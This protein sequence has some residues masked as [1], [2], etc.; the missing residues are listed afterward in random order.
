MQ[1]RDKWRGRLTLLQESLKEIR[2][3][4]VRLQKRL[5]RIKRELA[6][7]GKVSDAILDENRHHFSGGAGRGRS[8]AD[9][10]LAP[11]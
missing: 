2:S 1:E 11:R 4:E 10:Q 8:A 7:L 9:P 6:Q 3:R 5:R